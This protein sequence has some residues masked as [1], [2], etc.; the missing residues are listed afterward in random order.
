MPAALSSGCSASPAEVPGHGQVEE[1]EGAAEHRLE[2][3][4]VAEGHQAALAVDAA[5]GGHRRVVVVESVRRLFGDEDAGYDI[6]RSRTLRLDEAFPA[7]EV[8]RD[9]RLGP[10]DDIS[11]ACRL[12][13]FAV[14]LDGQVNAVGRPLDALRNVALD[15]GDFVGLAALGP[16]D[17][18][19]SERREPDDDRD[20]QHPKPSWCGDDQRGGHH[21]CQGNE[22]DSTHRRKASEGGVEK[23]IARE[24][25]REA[26]EKPGQEPLHHGPD[27]GEHQRD[28]QGIVLPQTGQ[29]VERQSHHAAEH[30]HAGDEAGD[31]QD[32]EPSRGLAVGV[33]ADVDPRCPHAVLADTVVPTD[34]ERP[35]GGAH[36]L[37]QPEQYSR[38]DEQEWPKA[39]RRQRERQ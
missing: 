9:G 32:G 23:G 2:R 22:Q 6:P 5:A 33:D 3:Q 14:A 16:G 15:E 28:A 20:R 1:R 27:H 25:P 18:T 30:R 4:V 36:V 11:I 35:A 26:R 12:G 37:Q 38:R 39:E 19:E 17:E 7:P 10:D 24:Q 13:Q 31:Q 29:G 34:P 8:V 21:G